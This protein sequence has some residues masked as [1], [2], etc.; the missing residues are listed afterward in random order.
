MSLQ[1]MED[2][3]LGIAL[4]GFLV[5]RQ[6]TWRRV[7]PARVW[8]MPLVLGGVGVLSLTHS[9]VT[10]VGTAD[11][12]FLAVELVSSAA[13]GAVMGV[14]TRFRTVAGPT[15]GAAVL[16]SRTGW[17]GA[18][19]WLVL[20]VVRVGLDVLGAHVGAVLLASTGTVL[21]GIAA[22]RAARAAVL[23][24]RMPRGATVR[25]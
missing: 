18:S 14:L 19:L 17:A 13:I 20:I 7:D 23:D 11:V 24:R 9:G 16:Q 10:H 2:V 12:A 3:V 8:R 21:L 4:V 1:T 6:T 22:N 15:G 5:Y 25:A